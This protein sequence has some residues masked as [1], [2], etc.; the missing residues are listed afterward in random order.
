MISPKVSRRRHD[1]F[2]AMHGGADAARRDAHF[3]LLVIFVAVITDDINDTPVSLPS[4]YHDDAARMVGGGVFS[5][6]RQESKVCGQ[7]ASVYDLLVFN[8]S[9]LP[10]ACR[11]PL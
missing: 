8:I 1:F 11:L 3:R 10:M 9:S 7:C 4:K 2:A 5:M 6:V